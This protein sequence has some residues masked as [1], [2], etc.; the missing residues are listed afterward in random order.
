MINYLEYLWMV[1]KNEITVAPRSTVSIQSVE[2]LSNKIY[3]CFLMIDRSCVDFCE[4]TWFYTIFRGERSEGGR[5]NTTVTRC[6]CIGHQSVI[7]DNRQNR[8]QLNYNIMA[9]FLPPPLFL[10]IVWTSFDQW[11]D[12]PKSSLSFWSI[13]ITIDYRWSLMIVVIK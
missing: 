7:W 8:F 4:L 13:L 2:K 11:N 10:F 12:Q 5:L 1:N 3:N 6:H 9:L